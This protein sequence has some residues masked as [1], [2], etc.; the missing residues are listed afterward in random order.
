MFLIIYVYI[1]TVHS[2]L[3]Q[4]KNVLSLV[5][6]FERIL[7]VMIYSGYLEKK[8]LSVLSL[9]ERIKLVVRREDCRKA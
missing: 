5:L 2:Y 8:P 9:L 3:Y 4:E 1:Y 7:I 6:M